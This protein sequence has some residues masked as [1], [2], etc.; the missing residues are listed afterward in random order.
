[1][2]TKGVNDGLPGV[3]KAESKKL[4]LPRLGAFNQAGNESGAAREFGDQ[5]VLVRGVGSVA[6]SAQAV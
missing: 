6:D 4:V 3:T 1:M 2:I 5:D